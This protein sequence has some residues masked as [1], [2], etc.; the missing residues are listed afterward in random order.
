MQHKYGKWVT[1]LGGGES[2]EATVN[3]LRQLVARPVADHPQ[4]RNSQNKMSVRGWG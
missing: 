3:V 4:L 2:D 1:R